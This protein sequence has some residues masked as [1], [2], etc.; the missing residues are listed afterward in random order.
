MTEDASRLLEAHV[1]IIE[2]A[3]PAYTQDALTAWLVWGTTTVGQQEYRTSISRVLWRRYGGHTVPPYPSI[4][5]ALGLTITTVEHHVAKGLAFLREPARDAQFAVRDRTTGTLLGAAINRQ[6]RRGELAWGTVHVSA[7]RAHPA[8]SLSARDYL[9]PPAALTQ[10]PAR[11]PAR[12]L[13]PEVDQLCEG[14]QRDGR[15]CPNLARIWSAAGGYACGHH[16]RRWCR[17]H[18]APADAV[19]VSDKATDDTVH[20]T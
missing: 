10:E 15:P 19:A 3:P 7:I 5:Q 2:E 12:V 1:Q 18:G 6:L 20:D 16:Y 11:P 14:L 17:E 13:D 8:L 9:P 4:A